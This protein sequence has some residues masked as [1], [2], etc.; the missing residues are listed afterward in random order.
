[1]VVDLPSHWDDGLGR[2]A[3]ALGSRA[4]PFDLN[5][6]TGGLE[7]KTF[8]FRLGDDRFVLKIYGGDDDQARTE[9]DNLAVVSVAGVPT[10]EPV[11][12]DADGAWFHAPA[13]VMTELPGR[14]D[15]HPSDQS[16]WIDG[17]AKALASVH[18]VPS[19]RAGHVRPSRWQR[20]RP[21][22]EGMGSEALRLDAMLAR[23]YDRAATLPTVLSHD[24]F[25]PGNLLYDCGRLS[26]VVDWADITMEPRYAAVALYRHFLAIHPGGEA[27]ESFL[28][29]YERAAKTSL[30]DIALWDVLYG[31]RGLRPIDHWVRACAGLGLGITSS[32]IQEK[33][34]AWVRQGMDSAGG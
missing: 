31:L 13:I 4:L 10:P 30:D 7:G 27:P 16:I 3:H 12:L 24:D 32:E 28:V 18:D 1:V 20:W 8:A 23:L 33:S 26:G 15:M 6:F 5:R 19:D 11:L 34:R 2:M 25:N 9:F 22:I 29:A 14:P 21:S 17:A